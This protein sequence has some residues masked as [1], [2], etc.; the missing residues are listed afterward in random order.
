[1]LGPSIRAFTMMLF[2]V[3]TNM[4]YLVFRI[5]GEASLFIY[6]ANMFWMLVV[7]CSIGLLGWLRATS[8]TYDMSTHLLAT[9]VMGGSWCILALNSAYLG[10]AV[11]VCRFCSVEPDYDG[12]EY[13]KFLGLS[14]SDSPP[15]VSFRPAEA[16]ISVA[17]TLLLTLIVA[18][19]WKNLHL[20]I[21]VTHKARF[22][23]YRYR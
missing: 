4:L 8:R 23:E 6:A 13:C 17:C 20:R 10:I 1:M 2:L 12:L 5:G 3:S 11:Y 18:I 14:S 22:L 9:I 7:T 21:E 19:E 15:E 16:W